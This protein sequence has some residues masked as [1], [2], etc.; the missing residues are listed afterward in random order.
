MRAENP[1]GS[2]ARTIRTRPARATISATVRWRRIRKSRPTKRPSM[3]AMT[4]TPIA[5]SISSTMTSVGAT[6]V[7]S[8]DVPVFPTVWRMI[9]DVRSAGRLDLHLAGVVRRRARRRRAVGREHVGAATCVVALRIGGEPD[10]LLETHDAAR[11]PLRYPRRHD[12]GPAIVEDA[13]SIAVPDAPRGRIIRMD[14]HVLSVGP[15]QDRLVV[16][17]RVRPR[18]R[19]RCDHH[20]GMLRILVVRMDV[21]RHRRDLTEAVH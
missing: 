4:T 20:E 14:P 5:V 3:A 6:R 9:R 11:D 15:R 2:R 21:G 16:V 12:R 10:A 19:F 1:N 8:P 17:N 13:Y 7:G 18:A